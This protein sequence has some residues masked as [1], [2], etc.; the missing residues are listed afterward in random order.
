MY[1]NVTSLKSIRG[2]VDQTNEIEKSKK[3]TQYERFTKIL[4]TMY[5]RWSR[6]HIDFCYYQEDIYCYSV[7]SLINQKAVIFGKI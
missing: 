5:Y 3:V 6:Y 4:K 7:D 2:Y 1:V